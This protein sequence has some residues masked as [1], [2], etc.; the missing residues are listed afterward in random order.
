MNKTLQNKIN[1]DYAQVGGVRLHYATAGDGEKL[2]LL[3]HGFPEFWYSWRKQLVDL[4]DEYTVVAP[5]MR[6]YNLSDKPE[7]VSDYKIE[8]LVDDVTG[9]INHFG[10]KKAFVVG[11]DWGAGVAWATA[12]RHPE[13]VEKLVALQVPPPAVWRKNQTFGQLLASW[14]MF[15]FQIPKLPEWLLSQ[16]NFQGLE[17]GLKNST[18]EKGIFSTEE[19][20]EY[21][22]AWSEQDALKSAINY[23]RANIL[24]RLF[25]KVDNTEKIKVPTLFIYGEQDHAILPETVKNIGDFIDAEYEE[26]RIP[27]AGHWVQQEAPKAVTDSIREFLKDV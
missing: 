27:T 4:S 13:Y 22:K 24:K 21:K 6:G 16:N 23:Y 26:I 3:L 15:L 17:D 18:A 25:G 19:I 1:F 2:V 12:L 10:H 9:L 20:A 7:N 5:D 14:Y 8:K 11:H